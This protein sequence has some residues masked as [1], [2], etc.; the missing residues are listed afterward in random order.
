MTLLKLTPNKFFQLHMSVLE[1]HAERAMQVFIEHSAG[2]TAFV[3]Q[4]RFTFF[5]K[6][7]GQCSPRSAAS[8]SHGH[9]GQ[10]LPSADS[11]LQGSKQSSQII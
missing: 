10:E 5:A 3:W 7:S 2:P 9:L 8:C 4:M 6:G 11:P 1:L